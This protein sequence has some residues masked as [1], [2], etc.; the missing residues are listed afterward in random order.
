MKHAMRSLYILTALILIGGLATHQAVAVDEEVDAGQAEEF[1]FG[2]AAGSSLRQQVDGLDL[3]DQYQIGA[4]DVVA[5][6]VWKDPALSRQVAVLPDG[7]VSLPLVGQ[8]VVSGKTVKTLEQEIRTKI[9]KY[10]PD[11]VLDVSVVAVNSMLVYVIGKVRAPGRYAVQTNIN[12]LQLLAIAGGLDKHADEDDIKIYREENHQT[13]IFSF[14]YDDVID[15]E[16]LEQNI[17]LK[18]GDVV[19]VP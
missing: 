7:T 12:V 14:E 19:V 5:L 1:N 2:L 17:R 9:K 13:T 6:S 16:Q 10:L 3:D 11:P 8:V 18:R 4:G 15:G